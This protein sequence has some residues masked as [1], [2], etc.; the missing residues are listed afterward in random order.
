[1]CLHFF[2]SNYLLQALVSRLLGKKFMIDYKQL[3]QTKAQKYER[4]IQCED[5]EDNILSALQ[6]IVDLNDIDVVEL[7]AG[8]GRLTCILAPLVK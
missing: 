4:L 6:E 2:V 8:T 7:G 3:Y 1:M 5:Y